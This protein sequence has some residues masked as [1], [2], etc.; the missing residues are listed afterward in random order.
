VR[1]RA[2]IGQFAARL[3]AQPAAVCSRAAL[4]STWTIRAGFAE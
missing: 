2:L 4:A 3:C 1:G